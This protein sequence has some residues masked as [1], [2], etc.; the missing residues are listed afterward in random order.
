[1]TCGE[2][3]TGLGNWSC[4]AMSK[5]SAFC[6]ASIVDDLNLPLF[7]PLNVTPSSLH[8][9]RQQ[10]LHSFTGDVGSSSKIPSFISSSGFGRCCSFCSRLF[11]RM[12]FCNSFCWPCMAGAAVESGRMFPDYPRDLV[13]RLVLGTEGAGRCS[14]NVVGWGWGKGT[15]VRSAPLSPAASPVPF[16]GCRSLAGAL[17]PVG[18]IVLRCFF[19]FV[20]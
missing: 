14:K 17:V 7:L 9:A 2:R 1:M 20:S 18:R 12:C 10:P 19:C 6:Y 8:P 4:E 5:A 3:M 15:Y 11:A 16:V 13:S